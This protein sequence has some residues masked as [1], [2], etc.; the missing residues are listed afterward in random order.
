MLFP[1]FNLNNVHNTAHIF[2]NDFVLFN[3]LLV[4]IKPTY[5][6]VLTQQP[7]LLDQKD[8][9]KI[10]DQLLARILMIGKTH[11]NIYAEYRDT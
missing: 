8:L 2:P 11:C 4:L 1:G 10:S 9:R 3:K 6:S 5:L 7:Y